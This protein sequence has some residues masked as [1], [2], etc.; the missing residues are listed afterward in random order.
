MGG[1]RNT[2]HLITAKGVEHWPTQSKDE[3]AA[4]LVAR[5]ADALGGAPR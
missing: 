4:M 2:I 3:V 5:I 1:D